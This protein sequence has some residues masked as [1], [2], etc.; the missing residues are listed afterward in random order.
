MASD[1][2]SERKGFTITW[3]IENFKYSTYRYGEILE[4]PTF[5]VD[6]MEETKWR[7]FLYPVFDD[8]KEEFQHF[9]KKETNSRTGLNST[10]NDKSIVTL[11]SLS[12]WGRRKAF[13]SDS[14]RQTLKTSQALSIKFSVLDS[15]GDAVTCGAAEVYFFFLVKDTKYLLTLTKKEIMRNKSQY[16]RDGVLSLLY[17]C[18]FTTG[19]VYAEIENTNY[20]WIP[21]QTANACLPDLKLAE[22]TATTNPSA[23]SILKRDIELMLHE[24]VLC[25][26]KLRTGAE[27]FPAHW[28]IL[29]AR[30]AVFR[31]MFESDMKEKAQYCIHIEDMDAGTVRRLLLY[32]YT[33]ACVDLQWESALQL[34]AAADKYQILSLKDE[35]SSFLKANLDAA[36]ACEALMIADLHHDEHLYFRDYVIEI[37]RLNQI[38]CSNYLDSS[39]E[40]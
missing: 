30:S 11:K 39:L 34:Y 3:I 17:E 16:L 20:G 27:T 13:K 28:F 24:N 2:N 14:F 29:S 12:D 36:N 32:M 21:H 35:C 26:V 10:L 22:S 7:L 38:N 37:Q 1:N 33:D 18:N 23:P 19:L 25:D 6:T 8:G 9:T 15:N 5:V 31:A 40:K 4:S